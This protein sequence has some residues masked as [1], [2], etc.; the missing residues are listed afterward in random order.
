MPQKQE[1]QR[2][3]IVLPSPVALGSD[4]PN[5][6]P[7]TERQGN[8]NGNE[9]GGL[10]Y[11]FTH[12]IDRFVR[13]LMKIRWRLETGSS[14]IAARRIDAVTT[15]RLN[16]TKTATHSWYQCVSERASTKITIQP[17]DLASVRP[18]NQGLSLRLGRFGSNDHDKSH[19]YGRRQITAHQYPD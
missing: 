10:R 13:G 18:N 15:V 6:G 14:P 11:Q 19:K 2:L 5:T 4:I 3:H 1:P 8:T 17:P 9:W 7:K 16:A 12:S